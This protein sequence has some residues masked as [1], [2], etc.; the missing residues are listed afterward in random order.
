MSV[1]AWR[2]WDTELMVGSD[3]GPKTRDRNPHWLLSFTALFSRSDSPTRAHANAMHSCRRDTH[4][5]VEPDSQPRAPKKL[6]CWCQPVPSFRRPKGRCRRAGRGAR[7]PSGT[8]HVSNGG[9]GCGRRS[10]P[11]CAFPPAPRARARGSAASAVALLVR[12]RARCPLDLAARLALRRHELRL[13]AARPRAASRPRPG[14]R[15]CR[16]G[17]SWRLNTRSNSASAAC[18]GAGAV[19]QVDDRAA[20]QSLRRVRVQRR[21]IASSLDRARRPP[22]AA[23]RSRTGSTS[24]ST[25]SGID[26]SLPNCSAGGSATPT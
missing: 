4:P 8:C 15:R 12:R 19:V 6:K 17:A 24:G 5:T 9:A 21:P 2:R 7:L 25:S 18:A 22:R 23:T 3:R 13:P 10:A 16:S 11:T 20:E 26:I 1:T 14:T